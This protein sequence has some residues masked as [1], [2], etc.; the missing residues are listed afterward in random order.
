MEKA[1]TIT[2]P[3]DPWPGA[4]TPPTTNAIPMSESDARQVSAALEE[5]GGARTG[6][7]QEDS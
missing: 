3:F 2:I 1:E 6:A 5:L 4:G 7:A